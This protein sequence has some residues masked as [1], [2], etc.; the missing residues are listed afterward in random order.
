MEVLQ[1][2]SSGHGN[3]GCVCTQNH[4]SPGA[5]VQVAPVIRGIIELVC[6]VF[7]EAAARYVEKEERCCCALLLSLLDIIHCLLKHIS[8]VVRMALQSDSD[9]DTG[10]AEELLHI[11]KPLTNLNSRLIQMLPC[12][13]AEVYEEASQ[14]VSLLAQLYGGDPADHLTPEDLLSLA[15]SLQLRTEPRQ[16]RLLLR[17][18][19]RLVSDLVYVAIQ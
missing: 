16:Q 8:G 4:C 18:L 3:V 17:V 5:T 10:E 1:L 6:G 11:N 15:Q 2:C 19:K 14:C 7:M 12:G 13:D 9:G